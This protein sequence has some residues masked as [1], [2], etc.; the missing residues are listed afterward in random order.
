MTALPGSGDLNPKPS[1]DVR[2][3]NNYSHRPRRGRGVGRWT[4]Q[5]SGL[6]LNTQDPAL[7]RGYDE[8][9]L[10]KSFPKIYKYLLNYETG[11]NKRAGFL[12]YFCKP[13][14]KGRTVEVEPLA[15]FYSIYNVSEDTFAPYKTCW[16]EQ[17]DF[18]TSAVIGQATVG[19]EMKAIM[20]DHKVMFVPFEKAEEAHFLCAVLNSAVG[21]LLVKGL[22]IETQTSTNILEHL[23][24]PK[25][26][27]RDRTHYRLAAQ[28]D[29]AHRLMLERPYDLKGQISVVEDQVD[30]DV[31]SLWSISD[32][33]LD[34][35][36][37]SI[38]T[39]QR[40]ERRKPESLS[41]PGL[42]EDYDDADDELFEDA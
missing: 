26:S 10:K 22:V 21:R 31:A 37:D 39:L 19:N 34:A 38:R 3:H 40:I 16:R 18:L 29:L 27:E 35:I 15:P 17:A 11:L 5:V 28:S 41:L 30:H 23:K 13:V 2:H 25:F 36:R 14:R 20:P 33:E 8:A 24:I 4:A 12:K 7:R 6:L 32:S 1:P 42:E 9:T